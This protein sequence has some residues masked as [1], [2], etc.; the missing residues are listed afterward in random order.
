MESPSLAHRRNEEH[1][2]F[3]GIEPPGKRRKVDESSRLFDVF[4]NHRG[5]DVK[6]T[7]ALQ[8]YNSVKQLGIHA[9]L[10]LEEK[11]PGDSFPSTIKNAIHSA[12]AHI[13]IFSK[14]Y[15][16]SPWC[17]AELD[18]M[19]Q[20]KAKI[21]TV[22]YE[23]KPSA[24]RH[25]QS[26]EYAQSFARYEEKGRYSMEKLKKWKEALH[27]VSFLTGYEISKNF[28]DCHN[29]VSAVDK[30]VQS[31]KSIHVAKYPVGLNRLV[32]DFERRCLDQLV[33]D[34]ERECR[35][36]EG[37]E[38]KAQIVGIFGM[39]G[40]GKT[41]LVKELF[42]RKRS[43][44]TRA[45]F[46]SD[47]REAYAKSNEK[48]T[49]LQMK[50]LKDLYQKDNLNFYSVE[51]GTSYIGDCIRRSNQLSFLI[52]LDD[53]DH[54]KQ[55][56]ALLIR[57]M[58]NNSGKS[59]VIVTTRDAGVLIEADITVGYNLKGMATDE[60]KELF[61]WH[62]FG[63]SS[64]SSGYEKLVD[65]FV[66]VCS[67]LPLSLQVLGS[68][69]H[70]RSKEFWES[71]LE[72]VNRT[73]HR[74]IKVTLKISTD[75]LDDEEKQIFMDVAC[76]FIGESK[77]KAI[78]MWE[79]SRWSARHALQRL[80]DKCLVEEINDYKIR[81]IGFSGFRGRYE[82][83]LEAS[84]K[85][86]TVLRMHD[87]L[88][89]LGREMADD[90]SH[91]RRLWRS[92][93]LQFLESK[94]FKNILTKPDFRCLH[95]FM[96]QSMNC[97]IKYF[98]GESDNTLEPST[99][100][101]WLELSHSQHAI[102]NIPAWIPL[103]NLQS[104]KI[105]D[106]SLEGLWQD[107]EQAP[108]AL[109]ELSIYNIGQLEELSLGLLRHLEVLVICNCHHLK[110]VTGISALTK[111]VILKI[112]NCR[113]LQMLD[114]PQF[115]CLKEII[116]KGCG[117]LKSLT[118]IF[119]HT[120]LKYLDFTNCG[121]LEKLEL[122]KLDLPPSSCLKRIRI[123]GCGHLKSVTGISDL[124]KLLI[125]EVRNCGELEKLD[126]P[127]FNCL[128]EI[129]INDCGHLKS[130][131]GMSDLTELEH[132][133]FENCG[134]LEKLDFP[135]FS[136]LRRIRINGCGH[137]KSVT[138]LSNLTE[139]KDLYIGNCGKV[140]DL[141]LVRLNCGEEISIHNCSQLISVTA[142]NLPKL[143]EL[144]IT[145]CEQLEELKIDKCKKL[146]KLRLVPFSTQ[147]CDFNFEVPRLKRIE[148]KGCKNLL[149]VAGKCSKLV[150]LNIYDSPKL[151]K[152][153]D[154]D[155]WHLMER[156]QLLYCSNETIRKYLLEMKMLPSKFI[157]VIGQA[158]DGAEST[159]NANLFCDLDTAKSLIQIGTRDTWN[160]LGRHVVGAIILCA[161]V[162]VNTCAAAQTMNELIRE[163]DVNPWLKCEVRQG[164]WIITSLT[165]NRDEI[166]KLIDTEGKCFPFDYHCFP[167]D[168]MVKSVTMP[169]IVGEE[170]KVLNVLRRIVDEL[171]HK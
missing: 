159:V 149:S 101:L 22:F 23:V 33:E 153:P 167:E 164:K 84:R 106:R 97:H 15:A 1:Y 50:L 114:L 162:V 4:I 140:E 95:S 36:N 45:C 37:A 130:V 145:E 24:L 111:L 134:E 152:I 96:D 71:A 132:L 124:T 160:H 100:L 61:C 163:C 107:N 14:G 29:L 7:V 148:L 139:L 43:Q 87:H 31:K 44:Y 19:L 42:N 82:D 137:L 90:L 49:C 94:G 169:V 78:R 21:F 6:E 10:D 108:L 28:N 156:V 26:G 47:V 141:S 105:K 74:D 104:L 3:S 13:A 129:I 48:F 128:K 55:L 86:M 57:D 121:D 65:L 93:H 27:S 98:L 2:A 126:L 77:E 166:N 131:T 66:R 81:K 8:L 72:K 89:D 119:D 56:D 54:L 155:I 85:E 83:P 51:E 60:A 69:V 154:M 40:V 30:E 165:S 110:S 67:G 115:N 64:P 11:K 133:R 118:E 62:A 157:T 17:L 161:V 80:K 53:I 38:E 146:K 91:P 135:P 117:H 168:V 116:I 150:K 52:V 144:K 5:P 18:L 103:Q 102:T 109:K 123:A 73:L 59:L 63:H 46:L 76:F 79:A 70:G 12:S 88:R 171:Y 16:D 75:T 138:G 158:K 39:G 143:I 34:F 170:H 20:T 99:A 41:T 9:F 127:Q 32:K 142:S 113:E 92:Q 35:I 151:R 147:I 136:C 58:L 125:L 112:I 25:I 68:H 120:E 122:Q